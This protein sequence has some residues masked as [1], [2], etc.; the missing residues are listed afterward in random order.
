MPIFEYRCKSCATVFEQIRPMNHI[1]EPTACIL[2]G[3]FGWHD[4]KI[5]LGHFFFEGYMP[6]YEKES[7]KSNE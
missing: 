2:C 1:D 7:R 3:E 5:S 4:K 6:S